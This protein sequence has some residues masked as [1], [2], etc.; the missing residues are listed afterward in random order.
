[1]RNIVTGADIVQLITES[2][3]KDSKTN[4]NYV[5]ERMSDYRHKLLGTFVQVK[6]LV[7]AHSITDQLYKECRVFFRCLCKGLVGIS[8]PVSP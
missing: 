1:M 7:A 2:Q 8:V 6:E 4:K 3:R 5:S